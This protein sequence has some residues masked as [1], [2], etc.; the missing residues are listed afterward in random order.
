[1]VKTPQVCRWTTSRQDGGATVAPR[2][3]QHAQVL[4]HSHRQGKD[5]M[6]STGNKKDDGLIC[7]LTFNNDIKPGFWILILQ[8]LFTNVPVCLPGPKTNVDILNLF[9]FNHF[10]NFF[11]SYKFYYHNLLLGPE[12]SLTEKK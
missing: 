12:A 8:I 1:M 7:V 2:L 5:I 10:V 6:D 9:N 4:D 3:P 11:L